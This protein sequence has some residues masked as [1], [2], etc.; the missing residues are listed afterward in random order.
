MKNVKNRDYKTEVKRSI[1]SQIVLLRNK[2][3]VISI[4]CL[5]CCVSKISSFCFF[6]YVSGLL[7]YLFG[8]MS[9][10]STKVAILFF[11]IVVI[12]I[13]FV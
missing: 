1:V 5:S 13:A 8:I 3:Q 9:E 4:P 6:V 11:G 12:H 2:G 10:V 7:D